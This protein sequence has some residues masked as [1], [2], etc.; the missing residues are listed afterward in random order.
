MESLLDRD[1]D[2]RLIKI[3]PIEDG[4]TVEHGREG[5]HVSPKTPPVRRNSEKQLKNLEYG[6]KK[7]KERLLAKK[8]E[9]ETKKKKREEI[10]A[11]VFK[12][13]RTRIN[14]VL[15]KKGFETD[16][17]QIIRD[18]FDDVDHQV[19]TVAN[20]QETPQPAKQ[21]QASIQTKNVLGEG[22]Q[23]QLIHE[24]TR[25]KDLLP[26]ETIQQYH[27]YQRNRD[28]FLYW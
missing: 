12:E 18:V 20:E 16:I 28:G 5:H 17:D 11:K 15:S 23:K 19:E 10:K 9:R 1:H 14:K 4:Q 6:R 22:V 21:V 26:T 7:R 8:K 3:D 27:N 13:A 25:D 24:Q 2:T